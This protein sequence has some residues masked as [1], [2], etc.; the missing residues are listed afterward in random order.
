VSVPLRAL[1]EAPTVAGL[2]AQVD[3]GR[4]TG[5]LP[6]EPLQ[7]DGRPL[8]ASFAQERLWFLDK[9]AP[10][11]PL[12]DLTG[13]VRMRGQLDLGALRAAL[14]G[15]A[16]RHETLRTTLPAERGRPV[17]RV[18]PPAAVPLSVEELTTDE[19]DAAGGDAEE[20]AR[21]RARA[22]ARTPWDLERGPLFRTALLRLGDDDHVLVIG[23]HHAVAD[24]LSLGVLAS[25]LAALYADPHAALPPLPV[26]YAD[27]AAWQRASLTGAREGELLSFWREELAGV[28]TAIELPTDRPRPAR[29]GVEGRTITRDLPDA[30]ARGLSRLAGGASATPF[31]AGLAAFG[32]LLHRLTGGADLVGGTAVS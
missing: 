20:A 10:G 19:L 28:P 11:S 24:G 16:A 26:Q 8:P 32:A 12:Y 3:A 31:Q 9:L 27:V 25:E 14:D 23:L 6:L 18:A 15:V 5:W 22:L 7:R 4:G 17:Q 13:A 2:A 30:A 29:K 21:V 1:F